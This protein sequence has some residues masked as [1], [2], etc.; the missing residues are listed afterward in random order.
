MKIGYRGRRSPR[1]SIADR[2]QDSLVWRAR[3]AGELALGRVTR[4]VASAAGT[5][6]A[7]GVG[8]AR[9]T[10]ALKALPDSTLRGFAATSIGLGAGLYLAGTRRLVIAAGL[11]P[12]L[13]AGTAI[14][15]RRVDPA[16]QVEVVG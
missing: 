9:T 4:V 1:S 13:L 14:V 5:M 15:L 2:E 6:R 7:T 8:A 16:V 3:R 11:V 10:S 12:A